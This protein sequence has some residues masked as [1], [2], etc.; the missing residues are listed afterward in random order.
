LDKHIAETPE[1]SK[2]A[3]S[4]DTQPLRTLAEIEEILMRP[5]PQRLL[6]DVQKTRG[7][8]ITTFS[9]V[10]VVKYL[11]TYT[12]WQFKVTGIFD[13]GDRVAV[14]GSLGILTA[15]HGWIW[16][17]DVGEHEK[18]TAQ[19]N[20]VG[21]GGAAIIAKQNC[22]RRCASLGWGLGFYLYYDK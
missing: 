19:G 15:D 16:R 6:K 22:L 7:R 20:D 10:I 12:I 21:F 17:D 14:S 1:K 2:V 11:R 18:K 3:Q 8:K 9:H 4:K 5:I 13:L